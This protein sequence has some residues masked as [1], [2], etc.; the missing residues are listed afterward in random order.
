MSP[1]KEPFYE[2]HPNGAA[3][4]RA[5]REKG[6]DEEIALLRVRLKQ[7]VEQEQPDEGLILSTVNTIGRA[8]MAQA[9]IRGL[10]PAA[11]G[12]RMRAAMRQLGTILKEDGE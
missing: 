7:F 3:M 10:D 1:K 9:R 12:A 11:A 5:R 8:L 4:K 2:P 6:L